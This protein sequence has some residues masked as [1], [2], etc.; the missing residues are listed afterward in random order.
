MSIPSVDFYPSKNGGVIVV[1]NAA[2]YLSDVCFSY[3]VEFIIRYMKTEHFG[4][5]DQSLGGV[6]MCEQ[7]TG[8]AM[9]FLKTLPSS[10]KAEFLYLL[11]DG[12]DRLNTP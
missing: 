2:Q 12:L 3:L 11:Q 7:Y 5:L 6:E 4:T 8:I 10:A 1:F 9:R